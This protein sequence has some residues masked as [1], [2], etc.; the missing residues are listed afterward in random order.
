MKRI[1]AVILFCFITMSTWA[2]MADPRPHTHTQ[3][4]GATLTVK[5]NG[6]ERFHFHTTADGHLIKLEDDGYFYYAT[7]HYVAD[8]DGKTWRTA[9]PTKIIAKNPSDRSEKEV[10]WLR[11][12]EEKE[13][14]NL[15]KENKR[16]QR[17]A[18]IER[19]KA[20]RA[21]KKALRKA[22]RAEKKAK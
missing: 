9:V 3:P 12:L 20:N 15:A 14:K 2:V 7:W 16:L 21:E 10:E 18:E 19:A 5:L 13:A 22:K 11:K 17:K 6:D 4:D 1:L 8:R